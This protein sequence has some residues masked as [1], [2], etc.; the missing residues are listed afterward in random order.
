ME[1]HPTSYIPPVTFHQ[2]P[3]SY[4]PPVA[5]WSPVYHLQNVCVSVA[6][7]FVIAKQ[8]CIV[9]VCCTLLQWT[10]YHWLYRGS[11]Q[12]ANNRVGFHCVVKVPVIL[13]VL[14]TCLNNTC[15]I[16]NWELAAINVNKMYQILRTPNNYVFYRNRLHILIW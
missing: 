4:I 15:S 16:I 10:I 13:C 7:M 8:P 2:L 3:L 5:R 14:S 11:T 9:R 6:T 12:M 1:L